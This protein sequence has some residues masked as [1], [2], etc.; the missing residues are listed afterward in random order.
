MTSPAGRSEAVSL[1][2]G[3]SFAPG[4][5]AASRGGCACEQFQAP[6]T[7]GWTRLFFI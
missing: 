6:V 3:I 5:T 4:D 1:E 7:A 2:S